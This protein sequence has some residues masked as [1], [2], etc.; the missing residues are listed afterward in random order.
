MIIFSQSTL[1]L[2]IP[3]IYAQ[4]D[5]TDRPALKKNWYPI[6]KIYTY[7][8]NILSFKQIYSFSQVGFTC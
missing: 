8:V 4:P 6:Q 5:Q 1:V 2:H 3:M 7:A